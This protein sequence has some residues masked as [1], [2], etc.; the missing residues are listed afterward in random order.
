MD[1]NTPISILKPLLQHILFWPPIYPANKGTRII[2]DHRHVSNR[3]G[4]G[5]AKL[6]FEDDVVVDLWGLII[7]WGSLCG[8]VCDVKTYRFTY[9]CTEPSELS[10]LLNFDDVDEMLMENKKMRRKKKTSVPDRVS[11]P[12]R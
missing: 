4:S 3:N 7:C 2:N 8:L 5:V 9:R 10:W 12:Q 6:N 1:N 11:V